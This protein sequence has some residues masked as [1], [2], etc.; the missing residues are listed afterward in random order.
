[1]I[2]KTQKGENMSRI[3]EK[4]SDF[5]PIS[6]V[7]LA[8]KL[9]Y[10]EDNIL[11]LKGDEESLKTK[12]PETYANILSCEHEKD[13]RTFMEYAKDLVSSWLFEDFLVAKFRQ[14][15]FTL[16]LSGNDKNRKIL[17]QFT[18]S[19]NSDAVFE[20]GS[21]KMKIEIINDYTGFWAKN[22]CLHLRDRKFNKLLAE[23]AYLLAI[24]IVEKTFFVLPIN[25]GTENKY[26]SS[27][28]NY[29]GKPAYEIPITFGF[30]EF[31]ISSI[32]KELL[33]YMR[34]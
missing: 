13:E 3:F 28:K 32:I 25:E 21:K 22:K 7:N 24:S 18:V 8:I 19:T 20:H 15:G 6:L 2:T 14:L 31:K 4:L 16:T 33:K 17:N 10:S 1:M 11:V 9:K 30:K 29:G 26:I 23:H 34:D 12:Y 27:H 5:F